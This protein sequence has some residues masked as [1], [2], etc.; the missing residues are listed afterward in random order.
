VRR[1]LVCLP[2]GTGKTV[3]FSQLPLFFKMKHRM[4]VLAHRE[5]LLEQAREKVVRAN[6]SLRVEIEQG[7]RHASRDAQIIIASVPTLGREGSERILRFA[8]DEI[9]L[10]V[11]DE[12]HHAVA[13]TYRRILDHF[14]LFDKDTKRLLLGFTATPKRGDGQGLD[15]VFE[16]IV[17]SRD[18]PEMV[19][20]GY[21]APLAGW[22]VTTDVDLSQ[23]RTRM[24]DY[25]VN[26]LSE[27]VNVERR[28]GV[29]VKAYRE[30]LPGR[31]TI[32]FCADVAHATSL[33][34]A[35]VAAGV[36]AASVTGAMP[37]EARASRR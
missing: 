36:P 11:V 23:V 6:P 33:N 35:F 9:F 14:G 32:C 10:F 17:F 5:E 13:E 34:E 21:L 7:S 28:N 29:V 22:R 19:Q 24:G 3:V 2:T 12:A 25:V 8:R 26:Q 37:R 16:E 27:A 18:L 15:D 1:Q 4:L 20:S 31:P 30:L